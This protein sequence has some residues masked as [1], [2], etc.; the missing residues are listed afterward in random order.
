M[1]G[2]L[3]GGSSGGPVTLGQLLFVLALTALM[4]SGLVWMLFQAI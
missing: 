3:P 2:G 4:I 1:L